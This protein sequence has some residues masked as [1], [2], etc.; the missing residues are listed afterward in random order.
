MVKIL[1]FLHKILGPY[2]THGKGE[3]YFVC[4]F[5][6]HRSPKLAI[7]IHKHRWHCWHCN[8]RGNS[9]VALCRRME[10]SRD[11]IAELQQ[12]LL[13]GDRD[14]YAQFDEYTSTELSLPTEFS[15][16]W[17]PSSTLSYRQA[18]S[19]ILKRGI[20]VPEIVRYNIGYCA[21]GSYAGRVIVPSYDAAGI[22]N[23][24]VAR[25][26]YGNTSLK[27]KNPPVSKNVIIFDQLINWDM[28]IVLCEGVFDAMAIKCNAIPILGKH[29]PPNLLTRMIEKQ[30]ETVYVMLDADA[31]EHALELTQ[32]FDQL[33]MNA[34]NVVLAKKDAGESTLTEIWDAINGAH[35]YTF[36]DLLV[37]KLEH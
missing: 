32:L 30:V 2:T 28:P 33:G 21:A 36:K 37:Q 27:Y 29:L 14:K 3:T 19:Y 25:A 34:R 24:F 1:A 8:E 4:P 6:Q 12:L 20:S 11:Q 5:C 22:L 7:N 35:E 15:P 13:A 31:Q 10:L 23:Y 9:L 26:F 18:L 17:K 16:L